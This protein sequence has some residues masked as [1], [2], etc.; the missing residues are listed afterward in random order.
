MSELSIAKFLPKRTGLSGV[1]SHRRDKPQSQTARPPNI[2]D[3]QMARDKGKNISNRNQG[4]LESSE[5]SS[6][7]TPN[8]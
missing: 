5:T 2:S 4:Y 1:Q 7:T 8:P 3:N 6:P